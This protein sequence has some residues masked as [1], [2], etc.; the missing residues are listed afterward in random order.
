MNNYKKRIYFRLNNLQEYGK[1]VDGEIYKFVEA[2]DLTK[3]FFDL[4]YK[5]E[6]KHYNYDENKVTDK[7]IVEKNLNL[8]KVYVEEMYFLDKHITKENEVE[9]NT[10]RKNMRIF[11]NE[12]WTIVNMDEEELYIYGYPIEKDI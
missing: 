5:N 4:R 6:Y 8:F 10:M 11:L 7:F 2:L 12:L 3:S 9:L 1:E